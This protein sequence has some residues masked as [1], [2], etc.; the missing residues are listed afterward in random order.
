VDVDVVLA[1]VFSE[2]RMEGEALNAPPDI[3]STSSGM[4]TNGSG[5]SV[6]FSVTFS[7]TRIVPPIS[8]TNY[9]PSGANSMAV[10]PCR[11]VATGES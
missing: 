11:P 1:G 8:A 7:M 6:A 2:I 5:S 10:G 3:S 9:R 4:V